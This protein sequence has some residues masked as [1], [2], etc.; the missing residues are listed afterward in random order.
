MVGWHHWLNGHEFEK[1]QRVSEGQGNL[2]CCSYEVAM[3]QTQLSDWTIATTLSLGLLKFTGICSSLLLGCHWHFHM[4]THVI[5]QL[6]EIFFSNFKFYIIILSLFLFSYFF[7]RYI[8]VLED[9]SSMHQLFFHI[10]S[11]DCIMCVTL[12]YLSIIFLVSKNNLFS[13]CFFWGKEVFI[14]SS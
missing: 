11:F 6:W 8:C 13:I 9:L 2:A 3:S 1:T 5:L 10:F 4:K 14:I 12:L 7:M